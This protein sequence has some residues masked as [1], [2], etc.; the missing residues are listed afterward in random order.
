[1]G[2]SLSQ[3]NFSGILYG[4]NVSINV[5]PNSGQHFTSVNYG[6]YNTTTNIWTISNITSSIS[7]ALITFSPNSYL[8]RVNVINGICSLFSKTVLYGESTIFNITPDPG[9]NFVST[10]AGTYSS[11]ILTVNNITSDLDIDI[12][13]TPPSATT[14]V[15][16]ATAGEG[17]TVAPNGAVSVVDGG[18][19]TFN[20]YPDIGYEIDKVFVDS[21]SQGKIDTYTFSNVFANHTINATFKLKEVTVNIIFDPAQGDVT[22][23]GINVVK[24]GSD[25]VI[26]ITP[27]EGYEVDK[28]TVNGVAFTPYNNR[29]ILSNVVK[30]T[31]V[32]VTFR[33]KANEEKFTLRI[34][35]DETKGYVVPNGTIKVGKT[36][37]VNF[38]VKLNDGWQLSG[39]KLNDVDQEMSNPFVL[40]GISKDSTIEF[41]YT[42]ISEG[43]N[44]K[45]YVTFK[46]G[47]GTIK[48]DDAIL[49]GDN[50]VEVKKGIDTRVSIVPD[51]GFYV[52]TVSAD[53]VVK[54]VTNYVDYK[55]IQEDSNM[56]V[57]L[58]N[59]KPKILTFMLKVDVKKMWINHLPIDI[60]TAPRIKQDRTFVPIRKIIEYIGG[61]I[62]WLPKTR[63]VVIDYDSKHLVL[64]IGKDTATIDGKVV[65]IDPDNSKVVPYI[66]ENSRTL[67][68]LRFVS[69]SLGIAPIW[70][71]VERTVTLVTIVN[72]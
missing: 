30:D 1:M 52:K 40:R 46:N 34:I 25:F 15:I 39:I 16:T 51:T 21:I 49:T 5:S 61:K 53:G 17:G 57:E 37:Q 67:L 43:E 54:G 71:P 69:E 70:D 23:G 47:T 19:K 62:Q 42:Q 59:K 12:V 32:S 14:H 26:D 3:S 18:S 55:N 27:K 48:S 66:D 38:V 50:W 7:D 13:F 68:P 56:V 33:A 28:I 10:S 24:Y 60:D 6:T 44:V 9:T 63:Q 72:P 64:T 29:F 2:A 41:F 45:I 8:V 20:I 11:G 22:A 31:Q 35:N 58:T 65:P 4:G 36:E